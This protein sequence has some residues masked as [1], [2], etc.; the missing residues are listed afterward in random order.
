VEAGGQKGGPGDSPQLVFWRIDGT[1]AIRNSGA[2]RPKPPCHKR[3]IGPS[4]FSAAPGQRA[5]TKTGPCFAI[6][7]S[8]NW[9][10]LP[11]RVDRR[12]ALVVAYS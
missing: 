5:L 8:K 11:E 6:S 10:P 4:I 12:I 1:F 3:Y 2:I 7:V 9:Q